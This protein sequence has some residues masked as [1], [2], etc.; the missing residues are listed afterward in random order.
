MRQLSIQQL[1]SFVDE[2]QKFEENLVVLHNESVR[3]LFRFSIIGCRIAILLCAGH[4]KILKNGH[5]SVIEPD[6][7]VDILEGT[8]IQFLDISPDADLHVIFTTRQ[9]IMDAMHDIAPRPQDYMIKILINPKVR[10]AHGSAMVIKRQMESISD[11][12]ADLRHHYR[13]DK[14]RNCFRGFAIDLGNVLINESAGHEVIRSVKKGD[15]LIVNFMSLVWT[16]FRENREISFYAR[17]MCITPKHLSRVV[18]EITGK[19][20]HDIIATEVVSLSIQLLQNNNLLIQQVADMLH[21][22]DQAAFSKFFRKYVGMSPLEY[23]RGYNE[24]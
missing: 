18:K 11:A 22:S 3:A 9:F 17:K 23:R 4:V 6:D 1:C 16:N 12:I 20:P 24:R 21:F 5:E 15:M 7:F 8:R 10:L 13:S 14:I 2:R 19:S